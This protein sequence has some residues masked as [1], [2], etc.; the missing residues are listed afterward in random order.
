M[1]GQLHCKAGTSGTVLMA[2]QVLV[3]MCGTLTA[4]HTGLVVP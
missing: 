2:L 4:G 1:N 3:T